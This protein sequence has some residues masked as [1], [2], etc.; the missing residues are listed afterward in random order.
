MDRQPEQVAA[1]S[2]LRSGR[3]YKESVARETLEQLLE[4]H[5]RLLE[6]Q[7]QANVCA[8]YY[9]R[10]SYNRRAAQGKWYLSLASS[11]HWLLFAA[12]LVALLL[13]DSLFVLSRLGM[14]LASG[15]ALELLPASAAS[16]F[17]VSAVACL[18][19]AAVDLAPPPD[20]FL[21]PPA[22]A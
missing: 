17:A 12:L 10:C 4:R 3:V 5:T 8:R 14:T 1:G 15:C 6:E 20:F 16:L 21:F 13:L 11:S 19:L 2:T 9:L 18:W 7:P 22:R